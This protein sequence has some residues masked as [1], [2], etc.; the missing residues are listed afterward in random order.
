MDTEKLLDLV[1]QHY[2]IKG[3]VNDLNNK[4]RKFY[5]E[6]EALMKDYPDSVAV[7]DS[8]NLGRRFIIEKYTETVEKLD[9][10][11]LANLAGIDKEEFKTYWDLVKLTEQ[12]KITSEM[13]KE[14]TYTEKKNRIKIRKK[15]L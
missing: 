6:I 1:E 15:K 3:N 11:H 5:E 13:V 10:D 7:L 9:K 12:G 2:R 4:A 8:V 14:A